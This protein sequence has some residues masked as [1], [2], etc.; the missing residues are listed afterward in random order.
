MTEQEKKDRIEFIRGALE[1]LEIQP[2][3]DNGANRDYVDAL[4]DELEQ[5][6]A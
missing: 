4:Y 5:L 1:E 2:Q 6:E 3:A